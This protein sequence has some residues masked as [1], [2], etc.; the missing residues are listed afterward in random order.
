M[1]IMNKLFFFVLLVWTLLSC[2]GL[3]QLNVAH[4]WV[5]VVVIDDMEVYVDTTNIVY[6]DG[7]AYAWVKTTYTTGNARALYLKKIQNS[8]KDKK[9]GESKIV[10]WD[11]FAYNISYRVYDC[12]N[13]RSKILEVAD[14][15]SEGKQIKKTTTSDK[16]L[17]WFDFGIDSVGDNSLYY[18]CDYGN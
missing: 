10:Q 16:N 3:K 15:T 4:S 5:D 18:I 9:E 2:S 7:F 13:K 6:K 17:K 12:V 1:R 8:Y 11:G 14:Y